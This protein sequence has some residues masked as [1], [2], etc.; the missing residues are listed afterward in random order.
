MDRDLEN[1]EYDVRW[2]V[3]RNEMPMAVFESNSL[4]VSFAKAYGPPDVMS[5]AALAIPRQPKPKRMVT[6]TVEAWMMI[7]P[8][9]LG[10]Q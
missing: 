5:I 6:K 10:Y 9:G 2:L 8:D 4:A 7:P 1:R 3:M